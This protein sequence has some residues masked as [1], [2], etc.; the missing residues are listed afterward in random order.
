LP[1]GNHQ[2]VVN[3]WTDSS[4]ATEAGGDVIHLSASLK[5]ADRKHAVKVTRFAATLD[6][7]TGSQVSSV[8]LADDQG[9]FVLTPPYSYTTALALPTTPATQTA[10]LAASTRTLSIRFD[11]LVETAPGSGTYFRQTVLDD[12][13]LSR[14]S[15]E[16]VSK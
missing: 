4:L 14:G 13:V 6:S 8:P 5:G 12:V 1:I 15:S 11:L 16:G 7:T 10:A 3:Y 9:E 2:L